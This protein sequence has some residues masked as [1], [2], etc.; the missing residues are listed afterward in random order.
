MSYEP[1]AIEFSAACFFTDAAD[2]FSREPL[3]GIRKQLG[4]LFMENCCIF[5][6]YCVN[7]QRKV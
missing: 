1:S 4:V 3:W 6:N 2:Y 5:L 7:L